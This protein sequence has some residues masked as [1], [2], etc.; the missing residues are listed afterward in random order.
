VTVRGINTRFLYFY[1]TWIYHTYEAAQ[2]D[3]LERM[4]KEQLYGSE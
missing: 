2:K 1:M 3:I 4:V